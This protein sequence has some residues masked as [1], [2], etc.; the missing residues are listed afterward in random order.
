MKVLHRK[1]QFVLSIRMQERQV[2]EQQI[3]HSKKILKV[4]EQMKSNLALVSMMTMCR[5]VIILGMRNY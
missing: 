1:E 2:K 5:L 3:E 4:Q